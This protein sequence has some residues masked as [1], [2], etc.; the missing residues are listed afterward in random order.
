MVN[1]GRIAMR[2]VAEDEDEKDQD[3]RESGL[4][5]RPA[6]PTGTPPSGWRRSGTGW[7]A[8]ASA[9][10]L[11]AQAGEPVRDAARDAAALA[12]R[13]ILD[14]ISGTPAMKVI[15]RPARD[16]AVRAARPPPNGPSPRP[17]PTPRPRARSR[18]PP[19]R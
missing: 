15:E 8:A 14:Q 7:P 5:E 3:Q 18:P 19:P 16:A 11:A 12:A 13:R 6:G 10:R 9:A 4:A 2:G 17:A 1:L